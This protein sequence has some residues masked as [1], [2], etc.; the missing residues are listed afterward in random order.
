[1]RSR[2]WSRIEVRILGR[3]CRRSIVA[4]FYEELDRHCSPGHASRG[5]GRADQAAGA[6]YGPQA[7]WP[8]RIDAAPAERLGVRSRCDPRR[9]SL[10]QGAA[11]ASEAVLC[12]H[13]PRDPLA[14]HR[15]VVPVP[16]FLASGAFPGQFI[17]TGKHDDCNWV[18]AAAA[19]ISTLSAGCGR[20]STLTFAPELADQRLWC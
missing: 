17:A 9:H 3:E 20:W 14:N 12:R 11:S 7:S 6:Q 13:F 8:N 1:M 19:N 18:S 4:L 5:R 16:Y 2:S 10:W 15:L